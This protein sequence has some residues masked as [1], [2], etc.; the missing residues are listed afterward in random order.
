MTRIIKLSLCVC[1][2]V[3]AYVCVCMHVCVL[4]CMHACVHVYTVT[5]RINNKLSKVNYFDKISFI[6]IHSM[7]NVMFVSNV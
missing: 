5:D 6:K 2:C 1:V 7:L 4:V 3:C